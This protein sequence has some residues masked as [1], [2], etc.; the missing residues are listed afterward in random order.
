MLMLIYSAIEYWPLWKRGAYRNYNEAGAQNAPTAGTES[1]DNIS[2]NLKARKTE[3]GWAATLDRIGMK[4][5][6]LWFDWLKWLF[7]LVAIDYS[8]RRTHTLSLL[9]L[10]FA[11]MFLFYLNI[12]GWFYSFEFHGFPLIRTEGQ[13]RLLSLCLSAVL[14]FV[15]WKW[16]SFAVDLLVQIQK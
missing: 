6:P 4:V 8:W 1:T 3:A 15:M 10:Y 12:Q 9:A 11:S 13:R 5:A 16:I 7:V 14:A 2:F